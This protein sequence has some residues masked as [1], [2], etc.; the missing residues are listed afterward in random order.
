MARARSS[1]TIAAHNIAWGRIMV[2]GKTV[3]LLLA[4]ALLAGSALA[5][6]DSLTRRGVLGLKL[7]GTQEGV[8]VE[9]VLNPNLP[10]IQAGDLITAVNGKAVTATAEVI[11]AL[12]RPRAGDPVAIVRT[13]AGTT[14]TVN[15][16]LMPAPTP[17]LDG[18]PLELGHVTLANGARIRT[19][20]GRPVSDALTR[21]GKA[22]ALMMI[23]GITCVSGE[24]FGIAD[25][26]DTRL[27]NT[28]TK[29]GFAIFVVDKPGVG[30]SEG[31][32][33]A[34][35]GFDVEVEAYRAAAQALKA[36]PGIDPSR[37]FVVGISMGGVQAPLIAKEI[38]F[39]GVVTWGTVVMPWYEYMLASFRRRM[40]LQG[41]PFTE[42]EP[43]LR[44]WRK[45]FAAA[46][47][48]GLT[49]AEIAAKM[50]EDYKTFKETAGDLEDFGGRSLKFAQECDKAPVA[51][52]WQAYDGD[53]LALHGEYDWV[54]ESYDH[55][56]A[57]DILN[58]KR[59]G[60]A[61]FEFL[62]GL[63]HGQT[64][65][66]SLADSFA[67]AFNGVPDDQF[68]KRVSAWLVERAS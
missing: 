62:K 16:K 53:L 50:P 55:A 63:D 21:D 64:R 20:L 66:A 47:V 56:L 19:E 14:E 30:D 54:A 36:T 52:S 2:R 40:V 4:A 13:R 15:E 49:S 51:A 22:P 27:Y 46:Y 10:G 65:H 41:T 35:G 3:S 18:R 9:E 44:V 24:V 38:G 43:M 42:A 5:E 8:K 60:S 57:A 31:E 6:A 68:E 25:H 58:D 59:P 28:L 48:D 23:N 33:C 61:T 29:A 26:P 32:A 11:A 45:V 1:A 39:K 12:G 7:T 67:N 37:L 17:A 34:T